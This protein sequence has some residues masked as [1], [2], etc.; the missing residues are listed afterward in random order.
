MPSFLYVDVSAAPDTRFCVRFA[1]EDGRREEVWFVEINHQAGT[2]IVR[3]MTLVSP[4][5]DDPAEQEPPT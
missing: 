5:P 2:G 4:S 3:R 1:P